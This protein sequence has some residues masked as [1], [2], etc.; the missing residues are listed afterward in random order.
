MSF[1]RKIKT[2]SGATAVQIARKQYG[3]IVQIDHNGSAHT[4]EELQ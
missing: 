4:E 1:I 2:D 3:R